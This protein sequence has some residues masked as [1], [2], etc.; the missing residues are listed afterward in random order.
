MAA[1]H[2][3]EILV[4]E[5]LAPSW[6]PLF[7]SAAAVVAARG[8]ILSNGATMARE[9]GIPAVVGVGM[10]MLLIKDGQW[11]EVDG[12]TGLVHLVESA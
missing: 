3:G 4:V 6:T 8:G 7:A 11:I 12:S 1:V 10:A 5:M 9:H 2:P